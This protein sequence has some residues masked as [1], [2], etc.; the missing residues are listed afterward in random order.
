MI[1]IGSANASVITVDAFVNSTSGTGSGTGTSI[2]LTAGEFFTATADVGDLWN[3]GALPR[4]S[5]ADGLT[6]DLFAV[7]GDDSGEAVGTLIGQSFG[8]HAQHGM[9][10]AFGTLV[11]SINGNFFSM[12]T[13]FAGNAV[14]TGELNLWYWDS[15][16][17]DN[18]EYISVVISTV[19]EPTTLALLALGLMGLVFN[20]RK[21]LQ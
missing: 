20:R 21:K 6:G 15:N 2:F 9:S 8:L 7:A 3:A 12:G 5:N 19:P 13:N 11:G 18:T 17:I 16:N 1:G 4:W 10:L 14:D